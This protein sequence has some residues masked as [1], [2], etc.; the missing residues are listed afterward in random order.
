M[1][2]NLDDKKPYVGLTD[3]NYQQPDYSD[4]E[5]L[6]INHVIFT[7][8]LHATQSDKV[9]IALCNRGS[10]SF[11]MDGEEYTLNKDDVFIGYPNALYNRYAMSSDLECQVIGI[12]KSLL[13]EMLYPN[14]SIWNKTL[15]LKRH[16][17]IHLTPNGTIVREHLNA[18]LMYYLK[19][20]DTMFQKEIV[21]SRQELLKSMV[22]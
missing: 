8:H 15:Y 22:F 16:H 19:R 12:T 14:Q 1:N 6:I 5:L 18:L 20:E 10:I 4:G 9:F 2:H 3:Y 11:E 21:T 17:I 13:L 7:P